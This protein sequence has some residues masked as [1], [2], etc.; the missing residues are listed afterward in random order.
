MLLLHLLSDPIQT[1]EKHL[2]LILLLTEK[3]GFELIDV[4][5]VPDDVINIMRAFLTNTVPFFNYFSKIL[6]FLT[7][8][9]KNML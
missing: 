1:W 9:M 7:Q 3:V 5:L 6:L 8:I 2:S 4:S